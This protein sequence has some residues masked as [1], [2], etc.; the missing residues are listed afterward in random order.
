MRPSVIDDRAFTGLEAAMVF[1]AFIVVAS[2]FSYVAL[3]TG[4]FTAQKTEETVYSAVEHVGSVVQIFEP[5]MVQASADGQHIRCIVIMVKEPQKGADIDV[6]RVVVTVSTSESMQT[7]TGATRWRPIDG[8][9]A[10]E[11][12][13]FWQVQIPL[14][15]ADDPLIP[16]DLVIGQNQRFFIEIKPP[17]AVPFTVE[18]TAPVGMNPSGWCEL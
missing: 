8:G 18:R 13:I 1:V 12:P 14:F 9:R 15:R 17:D 2:V 3:G 5:I 4:F 16:E 10:T 7:Y 6:E 11:N